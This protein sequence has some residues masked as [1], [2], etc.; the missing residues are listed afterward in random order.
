VRDVVGDRPYPVRGRQHGPCLRQQ[1]LPGR[2]QPDV[3]GGAIEQ[4][5]A[6][7]AFQPGELLAHRRLPDVQPLGGAHERAGVR[8]RR[9]VPQL[10]Q[11]HRAPPTHHD[12]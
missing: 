3:P 10:A 7:L 11:L 12:R 6:E 4:P 2:R 5:H 1:P 8:D 9:E